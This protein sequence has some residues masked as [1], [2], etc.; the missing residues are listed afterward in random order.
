ML[1]LYPNCHPFLCF[2][3]CCPTP[4]SVGPCASILKAQLGVKY[5]GTLWKG[6]I[7]SQRNAHLWLSCNIWTV[8]VNQVIL[9]LCRHISTGSHNHHINPITILMN[10]L[11]SNQYS[12]AQYRSS[13]WGTHWCDWIIRC[14]FN[15]I[16][17]IKVNCIQIESSKCIEKLIELVWIQ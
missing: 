10:M 7:K 9:V 1:G 17:K 13:V 5:F 8:G 15:K 12:D 4:T 16:K 2:H 11:L 3:G 6:Y 14:V